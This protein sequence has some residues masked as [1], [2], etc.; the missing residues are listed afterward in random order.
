MATTPDTIQTAVAH[1][2]AGR[3]EEAERMY[4]QI[5]QSN[6]RDAGAMHLLGLLAFHRGDHEAAVRYIV[7]AIRLDGSQAEFFANLA[8]VHRALGRLGEACDCYEAAVRIKPDM[9]DTASKLASLLAVEGRYA[10][11]IHWYQQ[12]IAARLDD[13][14]SHHG[15]GMVLQRCGQ[16]PE[17]E[18]AYLRALQLRPDSCEIH[19][20]LGSLYQ[21]QGKLDEAIA[22][23]HRAL[24]IRSNYAEAHYNWGTALV[25]QGQPEL[26][27]ARYRQ[28]I[29]A[30][31][32]FAEA[33]YNLGIAL[34][35]L[36][37][38]DEAAD[39]YEHAVLLRPDMALAH[40]NL[41][42]VRQQ[43]GK[44]S[45][46]VACYQRALHINP[47]HIEALTNLGTALLVQKSY[48]AAEVPYRSLAA[49]AP[50]NIEAH[51][52][53]GLVLHR[54]GRF[55]EA[56]SYYD[57]ALALDPEHEAAGYH[58]PAARLASGDFQ[59]G[60]PEFERWTAAHVPGPAH[61][62][63]VW[64]GEYLKGQRIV[65][66]GKWGLGDTLQF[67]RYAPLVVERGADVFLE[68]APG[69][70][71]LLQESGFE[72][73]RPLGASVNPPCQWQAALTSLPGI[74]NT[75]LGTI[76]ASV[77]YLSANRELVD[78]WRRRLQVYDDFKIGIHWHGRSVWNT[79]ERSFPL[80]SLEPL[81]RLGG[82][83]LIS[84]QKNEGAAELETLGDRFEVVSLGSN[85]DASGGA[86]MDTAAIM[87]NLDLIITC[88]TSV[89]HLAGGLGV[90]VWIALP[91]A[92]EWRWLWG[93][94][95]SPWYPTAR[96]FRQDGGD[97]A[98]VFARMAEAL[99]PIVAA[100]RSST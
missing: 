47:Q 89:A 83:T 59:R 22:S 42:N 9:A 64:H 34:Q 29:V 4:R 76:P 20:S 66:H 58:R 5:L 24:D 38:L 94:D 70:I 68:V 86:F 51:F 63:P 85:M 84:L 57:R 10:D 69:L 17:A 60:W 49:L 33:H 36:A 26:A 100:H 30:K 16:W 88:D 3:L 50:Q 31:A 73:L 67:V 46:A 62:E 79:D 97:W 12:A 77:P 92:S 35:K 61:Q 53:L 65:L 81:A 93:R 90:N 40:N 75:S 54:Q 87:N 43:Q 6:P 14:S 91:T 2:Q 18:T 21:A 19:C 98:G 96:L 25:A 23:Y 99:S 39:A 72:Q 71:P 27:V 80:I 82:V 52:N 56:V 32:D 37:Q 1:H 7:E 8:E 95:D 41:G 45:E 15:L 55:V 78:R 13:A 74:F 48:E 28:A 44:L 11:A